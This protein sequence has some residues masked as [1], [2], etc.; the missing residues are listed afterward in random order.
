MDQ[1]KVL[2]VASVGG[3]WIE[4]LRLN[5]TFDGMDLV[6]VSTNK[7]CASMV[8]QHKF[9]AVTDASRWNKFKLITSFFEV[10]KIVKSEK[11]DVIIT[12]GAAPGLMALVA[13]RLMRT[14]TI[15]V[16]SIAN[17]EEL[18]LSGKIASKIGSRVYTQWPD[19]VQGN[20]IYSGNI[21][22]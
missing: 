14:K 20:I 7:G 6:F 11:P 3:H 8:P 13:G 15:W 1:M 12:T 17:V 19:L 16:D 9:Y 18:S 22:S 10:F 2:A 5:R 21:L 4:L